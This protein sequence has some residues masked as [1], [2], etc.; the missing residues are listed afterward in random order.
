MPVVNRLETAM[1]ALLLLDLTSLNADDDVAAAERLCERSNTDYGPVAAVCVWPRFVG[2]CR[3]RLRHTGI[4]VASVANFPAGDADIA[5]A[6]R[7]TTRLVDAEVDEVDLVMPYRAWLDGERGL[8]QDLIAACRDICG[9]AVTLKVILETGSLGSAAN[10]AGAAGD[11]IEA[12]ADFVKSSTGKTAVSATPAAVETMLAVVRQAH[13]AVG[14][15]AAGGIRSV[16][17]AG[18]Y[19][20]LADR[21]MGSDW[22]TPHSFRFGA[23]SLLDDILATLGE[24]GG[25]L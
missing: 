17:Q 6:I 15:K 24:R 14:C 16:E 8:A 18:R 2:L 22:A 20:E 5:L 3:E 10:V 25:T 13:R 7:E 23:S 9:S 19:L 11:A 21:I 12:G 1:R 4:R